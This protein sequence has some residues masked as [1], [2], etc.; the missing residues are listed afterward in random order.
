MSV[1]ELSVIEVSV[2][3]LSATDVCD[4]TR[5]DVCDIQRTQNVT[6]EERGHVLDGILQ[7]QCFPTCICT[8]RA[9]QYLFDMMLLHEIDDLY[10]APAHHCLQVGQ[11]HCADLLG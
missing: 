5:V 1:T 10:G 2:T 11:V 6:Q 9:G 4:C 7:L 3:E 8:Q